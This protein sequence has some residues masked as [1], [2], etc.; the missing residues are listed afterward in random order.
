[1]NYFISKTYGIEDPNVTFDKAT[2]IRSQESTAK[3]CN[4]SNSTVSRTINHTAQAIK[5]LSLSSLPKHI[6][7]DEFKNVKQVD[8][9]MSFIFL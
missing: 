6:L 7:M 3:P 9:A 5:H 8:S 4:V 2:T 1:M